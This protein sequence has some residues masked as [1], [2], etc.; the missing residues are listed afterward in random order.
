MDNKE[1][2]IDLFKG[3]GK[4]MELVNEQMTE[5][6]MAEMTPVQLELLDEARKSTTKAEFKKMSS[7]LENLTQNIKNYAT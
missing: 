3:I 4:T 2:I 1:S 6:V 7:K 5:K